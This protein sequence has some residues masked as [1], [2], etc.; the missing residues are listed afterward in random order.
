[1]QIYWDQVFVAKL[2]TSR[3]ASPLEVGASLAAR[4]FTKEVRPDGKGPLSYDYDRTGG[5]R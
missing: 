2:G 3:C 1:M 5:S 4:G